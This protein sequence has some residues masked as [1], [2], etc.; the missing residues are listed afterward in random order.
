MKTE[1]FSASIY[2]QSST[3]YNLDL[4]FRMNGWIKEV[5]YKWKCEGRRKEEKDKRRKYRFKKSCMLCFLENTRLTGHF[6][7]RDITLRPVY[8]ST[9][10]SQP[11]YRK[12][13]L[14]IIKKNTFKVTWIE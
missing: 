7:S 1:V 3:Q 5:M 14:N 13:V 12:V 11:Y 9:I 8:R 2:C 10:F 6:P 4:Q